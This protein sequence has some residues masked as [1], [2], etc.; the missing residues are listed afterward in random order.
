MVPFTHVWVIQWKPFKMAKAYIHCC[1][2]LTRIKK[3][4]YSS[5]N[6]LS[7]CKVLT[8]FLVGHYLCL[9]YPA[10]YKQIS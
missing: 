9:Y 4:G 7:K 2:K 3:N 8:T 1:R 5:K 10:L 6:K